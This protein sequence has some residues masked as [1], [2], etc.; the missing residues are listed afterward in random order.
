MSEE[1]RMI[2]IYEVRNAIWLGGKEYILAEDKNGKTDAP[3]M[4]CIGTRN[5][6]LGFEMH[7][8]I[9]ASE[10]YFEIFNIFIGR[11]AERSKQLSDERSGC[12]ISNAPLTADDCIKGGLDSDIEGKVI[13]I[14]ASALSPEYRLATHQLQLATGGFGCKPDASGRAVYC[15]NLYN[16]ERYRYE[17]Y[18]VAG[19][20]NITRLPEWAQQKIA[21]LKSKEEAKT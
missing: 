7:E 4:T 21:E 11:L 14:K 12:G 1:K 6:Q 19:V 5:N 15:T 13:I 2:D 3:Y 20:A 8:D 18:D 10:D 17:R 9:L 16:G